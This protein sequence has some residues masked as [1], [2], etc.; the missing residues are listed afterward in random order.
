M[1]FKRSKSV[2]WKSCF[3][4]CCRKAQQK[5]KEKST[6]YRQQS[7]NTAT[8][9]RSKCVKCITSLC[10]HTG[11]TVCN[12]SCRGLHTCA[13]IICMDMRIYSCTARTQM[14]VIMLCLHPSAPD[15]FIV[16]RC[17]YLCALVSSLDFRFFLSFRLIFSFKLVSTG[18]KWDC[19][20]S[21]WS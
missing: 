18:W 4:K 16:R 7:L 17:V 14:Y 19:G 13:R 5:F 6:N 8:V 21:T 15:P 20:E 1:S 3:S 11:E 2:S 10:Y 9:S 12:L